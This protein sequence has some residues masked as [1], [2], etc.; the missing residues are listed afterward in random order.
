MKRSIAAVVAIVLL[1]SACTSSF[2]KDNPALCSADKVEQVKSYVAKDGLTPEAAADKAGTDAR[3]LSG[4]ETTQAQAT[5]AAFKAQA[6]T[7]PVTQAP[8]AAP[9]T[10]APTA[11]PT[12]SA[13]AS[14]SASPSPTPTPTEAPTAAPTEAPTPAPATP[15]P[16]TPSPTPTPTPT[17]SPSPSPSPTLAAGDAGWPAIAISPVQSNEAPITGRV[18]HANGTGAGHH[19]LILTSGPCAA[20]TDANGNFTLKFASGFGAIAI[21]IVVKGQYNAA[22]NDGPVVGSQTITMSPTGVS[23]LTITIQ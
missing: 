1:G 19:C 17:P 7:A 5:Y 15:K 4:D 16:A 22:T 14:P 9:T 2:A 6:T 18:V 10:A 23:G 11:S 3:C 12:P 13:S 21:N 20:T 8:T